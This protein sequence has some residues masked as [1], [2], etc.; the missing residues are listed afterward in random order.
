VNKISSTGTFSAWALTFALA[1]GGSAHPQE[2]RGKEGPAVAAALDA[3]PVASTETLGEVVVTA[4]KVS[5]NLQSV[6]IAVTAFSGADLQQQTATSVSDVA[7][8]TPGLVIRQGFQGDTSAVFQ[9]RGQYQIDSNATL[10]PSVGIYVDG[11][12]WAR[13]YGINSD[14]LDIQSVQTLKG[15]QGTLF[16]RNTTGGAIL[17]QTNDPDFNGVSGLVSG[18]YGRFEEGTGSAVLNLPLV[19]DKLAVRVAFE[20]TTRNGYTYDPNNGDHAGNQNSW[21][22]RG[23][24]LFKPTGN[25]SVLLS[26]EQFES[27]ARMNPFRIAYNSPTSPANL[28]AALESGTPVGTCFAALAACT[29]KGYQLLQANVASATGSDRVPAPPGLVPRGYAKTQTYTATTTLDTAFGVIKAI[30]GYRQVSEFTDQ[31]TDGAGYFFIDGHNPEDLSQYSVELQA[32]G[33]A[34]D[35]HLDFATGVYYFHESGTDETQYTGLPEVSAAAG[36]SSVGLYHGIVNNISKGVYGQTTYHLTDKLSLTGGLRYSVDDKGL[37]LNNGS[38][39]AGTFSAP[40][41]GALF[42][43]YLSACPLH[44][45]DSFSGTSYTA[46]IDYALTSDVMVYIKTAKG[47]RSGGENIRAVSNGTFV[48]FQPETAT[49]YE[50]GIKSEYL[51]HRLR[52]NFASYYTIVNDY[53]SPTSLTTPGGQISIIE[54]NAGRAHFY[55]FEAEAQALLGGGFRVNATVA[56]THA[57]YVT[58]VDPFTHFDRS[59]EPFANVPLWTATVSPIFTHDFG[60]GRFALRGDFIYTS[61]S[62]VYG[63][64]FYVDANGLTR[65]DT[66]GTVTDPAEAAAITNALT[67]PASV[68]VDAR[69]SVTVLDNRLELAAWGKNLTDNRDTIAGQAIF[70][71]GHVFVIQREPRTFGLTATYKFGT[72]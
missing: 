3:T 7:N 34:F 64:G 41:A 12:Y 45:G 1:G 72:L 52:V 59:H 30:G 70:G 25:F 10:D 55:G 54:T 21:E 47:Y 43:C 67:S 14:L 61:Q 48:P 18:T 57:E 23:K 24:L 39:N 40:A 65:N 32:T 35:N 63:Q 36:A 4:R 11:L 19:D 62:K 15:P 31:N 37:T 28:E 8:L 27:D 16:G 20:R 6:P 69:A 9:L 53:Q 58:Y 71:L 22:A 60:I 44:R 46:S 26:A 5:E 66:D 56:N 49:S 2:A 17:F 13:S 38:Y 50:T 33:K 29:A 68:I 42:T 51:D